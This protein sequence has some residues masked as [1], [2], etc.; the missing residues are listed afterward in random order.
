M[1][2][3]GFVTVNF[4]NEINN[5]QHRGMFQFFDRAF[6]GKP[7]KSDFIENLSRLPRF[8]NENL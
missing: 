4:Y 8:V 6:I 1:P 2:L 7:L 3:V 5:P